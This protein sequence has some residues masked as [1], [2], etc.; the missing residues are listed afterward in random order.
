MFR[1]HYWPIVYLLLAAGIFWTAIGRCEDRPRWAAPA[2]RDAISVRDGKSGQAISLDAMLDALAVAD[3][4]FLGE[5]HTDE[6][7]HRVELAVYEGLLQRKQ[8][9]VV[10]ALE[11]FERDVQQAL[12]DYLAGRIDEPQLLAE[13]RPWGNYSSAYRPLIERAK[14]AGRPVIA[15]NFP[16]SLRMRFA[17]QDAAAIEDLSPDEAKLIPRQFHPNTEAYWRRVDNA[18]RGHRAMMGAGDK[19]SRLYSTQSLWDN[20]M[21]ESCADAIEKY[22]E[23]MVLHINGGF[24]SAYWDGTVHQLQVRRPGVSIKTVSIVPSMNPASVE[25]EGEP[26]ADFVVLAEAR[27]TDLNDGT[28]SVYAQQEVQYRLHLPAGASEQHKVPLLIWLNDDGLTS[29]DGLDLWKDRLGS[30]AAIVVIESPYRE[31]QLDLGV[32]GRW[33]WPDTFSSDLGNM[34]VAGERIW[35]YVMRHYPVDPTR[36]CVAGEGAGGTVAAAI[37]L[38]SDRMDLRAVT[39]DPSHYAKLKDFPLPLPEQYGEV[40]PPTKSLQVIGNRDDQRWW[41]SELEQYTGIGIPSEMELRTEDPWQQEAQQENAIRTAL[42][43]DQL[44][45]KAVEPRRFILAEDDLPRRRHWSRLHALWAAADAGAPVAVVS[46]SPGDSAIEI[47]TTIRPEAFSTAGTLPECPGPFGG[48]TVVVLSPSSSEDIFQRW[49][50]IEE[51]DPLAK[52][53]RFHRLR[54]ARPAASGRDLASVLAKLSSEN[55]KNILIVPDAFC[56]DADSLRSLKRTVRPFENE[57]TLHW[58]P[59]LGGCRIKLDAEALTATDLPLKHAIVVTLS[60]ETHAIRVRDRIEL[61]QSMRQAGQEFT[62]YSGLTIAASNPAVE[63]IEPRDEDQPARYRLVT[64]PEAGILEISYEGVIRHE[65]SE[66][67]EEYTRGFRQTNGLIGAEGVYLDGGSDWVPRFDDR[68]IRFTLEV[69]LPE[70]WHV[71]SQGSG[72]S[73]NEQGL[74]RWESGGLVE[75]VY[76]VG[77]PVHRYRDAAGA[78]ETL[79]YL[80]ERDEAL[81]SKYLDATA[82]YIEMYRNLIGPYP[83]GKFALVEN[84]WETGYGMPSFTLLGPQVLRFPFILHSSYPHEI[85]HNWWGNSVFVDY[86]SGNWCEGLTAYLADHLVQEQ[87]G[88]GGDYRRNALQ[89][90]RNYVQEGRD[91]PLV[92]FRERHNAAT[93]AV[94]Y[95]KALMMNHML[96]LQ[97]GDDAFRKGLTSFYRQYRGKRASFADL[98]EQ[99]AA[100]AQRDLGDFFRQWTQRTG[101]A[102]VGSGRRGS[103]QDC[104]RFFGQ[105]CVGPDPGGGPLLAR[106]ARHSQYGR[107]CH[108]GVGHREPTATNVCHRHPLGTGLTAC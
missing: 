9:R 77:G 91:F 22:S 14:T 38:L 87:R 49:L 21:G 51:N 68:L 41:S 55:R 89:K 72:T 48:T 78:V 66:Q 25:L 105:R 46:E 8:D 10:L 43:L 4:V 42:G 18:V 34:V 1:P 62:L 58:L 40:A 35:G 69:P 12:D 82:R 6:T 44:E 80:H 24:H 30:E 93:E 95:G 83:Y 108:N 59:G 86:Q 39:V 90:Y 29:T 47:P 103:H 17:M 73:R 53:S 3:A 61:P 84:F 15:S 67:K 32:G 5:T 64:D 81:A 56:A 100:V 28:W 23:H 85:L 98:Q 70:N 2:V 99:F 92:E 94:G 76:L 79:V 88:L 11:M 36:V 106:C 74:A 31:T 27:A 50:A 107:G 75:Q 54:V 104:R 65:L 16:G 63:R 45:E 102:V 33:F 96:R 97:I 13:S 20:S 101:A 19:D 71:I 52:E 60:P 57:M 37:A 7:T 26:V